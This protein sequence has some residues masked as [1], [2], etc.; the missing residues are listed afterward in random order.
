MMKYRV[1]EIGNNFYPQFKNGIKTF[2]MWTNFLRYDSNPSS[3]I[4]K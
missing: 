4:R 1:K 3:P 2:W